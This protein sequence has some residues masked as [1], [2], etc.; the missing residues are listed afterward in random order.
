MV[1]EVQSLFLNSS[2]LQ[3][4][5]RGIQY[6]NQQS[7]I[8]Q[9]TRFLERHFTCHDEGMLGVDWCLRWGGGSTVLYCTVLTVQYVLYC[10]FCTVLTVL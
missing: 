10:T 1:W 7:E 9:R 2:F 3:R 6:T 4:I 5:K 8:V